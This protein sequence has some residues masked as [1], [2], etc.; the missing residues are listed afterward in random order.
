MSF[1]RLAVKSSAVAVEMGA[2][3][4]NSEFER[5]GQMEASKI[6]VEGM[7]T[8]QVSMLF[9]SR[10]VLTIVHKLGIHV[11]LN[12]STVQIIKPSGTYDFGHQ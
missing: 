8:I 6:A 5:L 10:I 2:R 4:R 7:H 12:L 1:Y 3:K 11:T 9:Y